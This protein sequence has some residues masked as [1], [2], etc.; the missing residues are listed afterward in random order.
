MLLLVV[1]LV[2]SQFAREY[3]WLKTAWFTFRREIFFFFKMWS[4]SG[5]WFGSH[6]SVSDNDVRFQWLTWLTRQS[7][8]AKTLFFFNVVALSQIIW[9][10]LFC[11]IYRCA[12]SVVD[13][14]DSQ[15]AREYGWL[16]SAWFTFRRELI[17]FKMRSLSG[18]WF[19]SRYSV[20]DI[21]VCF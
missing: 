3:R 17:F 19:G 1:D 15:F 4:L 12:L 20:S 2:D 11:L 13:L 21:D 7:R 10:S 8:I 16:K 9:L 5:K 14:V 18:N 6:Y